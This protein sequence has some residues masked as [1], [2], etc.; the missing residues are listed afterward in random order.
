MYSDKY[1]IGQSINYSNEFG[2]L[3]LLIVAALRPV[4]GFRLA[5][6]DD[7]YTF[8]L[9]TA[10]QIALITDNRRLQLVCAG[11]RCG[12]VVHA[13]PNEIHLASVAAINYTGG[14]P[15]QELHD[16]RSPL[17]DFSPQWWGCM[18]T[19]RTS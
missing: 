6:V 19:S 18:S 9:E 17:V 14:N 8:A 16:A 3:A 1:E 11:G 2:T 4:S 12:V 7:K 10:E 5:D 13:S 15:A